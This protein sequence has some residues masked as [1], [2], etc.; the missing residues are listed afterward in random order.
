MK[1]L[2]ID[3]EVSRRDV[4]RAMLTEIGCDTVSFASYED[5]WQLARAR[6]PAPHLILLDLDPQ[7]AVRVR[8][9]L[10]SLFPGAPIAAIS[11]ATVE[12]A[13][14]M[15]RAARGHRTRREQQL[16]ARIRRL[17]K[18]NEYLERL[19]CID[20]LTGVANR[21][22]FDDLLTTEWRRAAR[23]GS[24]L[25]LVMLDLDYFHTLNER[26]SHLGGD[27][28]LRR[29]AGAMAHCLHRPSDVVA[30]YGG[31]EFVALLPDTDAAGAWVVA[32]RLRVHVEQLALPH[33]GSSCSS[34]VTLSAG[35]ATRT[36]TADRS[37]EIL[38]AAADVALFRAKQEGRNRACADAAGPALAAAMSGH[39][40]R[41]VPG[42]PCRQV[43][44]DQAGRDP[45]DPRSAGEA[46][47][48][49]T[50][51]LRQ[52]MTSGDHKSPRS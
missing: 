37:C 45:T 48:L 34:V 8:R 11:E 39:H 35:M 52:V 27:A 9:Q 36:P 40:R 14:A 18:A 33:E 38:I 12:A 47:G 30:R 17:K 20:Q 10:A 13:F 3:G 15:L 25:S 51:G 24:P 22:H 50:Y 41:S 49:G 7:K 5:A 21:R 44:L 26:S 46:S 4:I 29:V 23:L 32:E 31:D 43:L 19:A 2:V 6:S 16:I 42:P 1:V 28:C